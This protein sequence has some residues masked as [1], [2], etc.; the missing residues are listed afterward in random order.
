MKV[1]E[2]QA[3]V[4]SFAYFDCWWFSDD[5]VGLRIVRAKATI[6][7][8]EHSISMPL[9]QISGRA[10]WKSCV[11]VCDDK[12]D[13][14]TDSLSRATTHTLHLCLRR[15]CC[16]LL[17]CLSHFISLTL[18]STIIFCCCCCCSAKIMWK[19]QF[20]WL[21][22]IRMGGRGWWTWKLWSEWK[23]MVKQSETT[24]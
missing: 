9:K 16:W 8:S 21:R 24:P 11:C 14:F 17:F 13:H 6:V 5:R 19:V 2:R 15:L 12:C 4:W 23:C 1:C 3:I 7:W 20:L 10:S 18:H 22:M